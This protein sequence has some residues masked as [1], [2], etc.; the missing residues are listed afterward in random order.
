MKHVPDV[1]STLAFIKNS[2][3][4]VGVALKPE[5]TLDVLT[6]SILKTVDVVHL[7]TV[8]PGLEGQTFIPRNR[9]PG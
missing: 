5:T 7:M 8:E 2:G 9:Y 4:K 1:E 3:I 6:D